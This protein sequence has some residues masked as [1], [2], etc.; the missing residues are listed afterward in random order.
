MHCYYCGDNLV[1]R[2]DKKFC[3]SHCRNAYHNQ[4]KTQNQRW[5]KQVNY[6]LNNN[7]KILRDLDPEYNSEISFHDLKNLGFD[8]GFHTQVQES[9]KGERKYFCYDYGYIVSGNGSF[10]L[11]KGKWE[12]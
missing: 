7:R 2:T 6:I 3:D 9:E 1:G 11:I 5:V 10:K 12:A 8:F 4:N